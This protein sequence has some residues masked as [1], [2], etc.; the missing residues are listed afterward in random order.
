MG[1]ETGVRVLQLR[2]DLHLSHRSSPRNR[3][4]ACEPDPL[5][6][7]CSAVRPAP[8][9]QNLAKAAASKSLQDGEVGS[10]R[11]ALLGSWDNCCHGG[12]QN[13]CE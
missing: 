1:F 8:N 7:V 2:H 11:P 6:R 12:G 10:L 9:L 13:K 5:Q 3:V 4:Q